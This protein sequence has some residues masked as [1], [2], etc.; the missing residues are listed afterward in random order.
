MEV[1][2]L[3]HRVDEAAT[4]SSRKM[5]FGGGTTGWKKNVFRVCRG[6]LV[7]ISLFDGCFQHSKAKPQMIKKKI[8][9]LTGPKWRLTL[10]PLAGRKLFS[11]CATQCGCLVAI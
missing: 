8:S 9:A 2:E 1:G 4:E 10:E 6:R 5:G 11:E 7:G 3:Q